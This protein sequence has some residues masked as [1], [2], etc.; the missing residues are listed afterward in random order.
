MGIESVNTL[1]VDTRR[2]GRYL[3]GFGKGMNAS[4][5]AVWGAKSP[6]TSH[7]IWPHIGTRRS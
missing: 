3:E 2:R 1:N 5:L 7:C 6:S 4:Q